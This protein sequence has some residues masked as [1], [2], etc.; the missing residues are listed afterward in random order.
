MLMDWLLELCQFC[1]SVPTL[2]ALWI[3][4]NPA[5]S[6]D[7]FQPCQLCGSV[8]TLPALWISSN[9]ASS[10]DQFQPCQ[11]CG[12]VPTLPALWISSNPASSVDQF[13][14]CLLCGSVPTLPALWISF[15][16][17]TITIFGTVSPLSSMESNKPKS[18]NLPERI[19]SLVQR[20]KDVI[21]IRYTNWEKL[22]PTRR[23]DS[24][25]FLIR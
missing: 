2:P 12:S 22:V 3:S 11:L 19:V 17:R 8:P 18:S 25:S 24:T 20:P 15:L 16:Y 1:G 21:L 14:P 13:Q 5:S 7:Q 9:P 4:S 10:V 6:V 23:L